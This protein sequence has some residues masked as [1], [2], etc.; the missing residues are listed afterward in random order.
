MHE[1]R[2]LPLTLIMDKS[3]L[4]KLISI[5]III[6]TASLYSCSSGLEKEILGAWRSNRSLTIKTFEKS[7]TLSEK[8][9]KMLSDPNFFGHLIHIYYETQAITIY[10]GRCSK[11]AYIIIKVGDNYVDIELYDTFLKEKVTTRIF[12]ENDQMWVKLKEPIR[13]Y[14]TRV[15]IDKL[16]K[17]HEC[18]DP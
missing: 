5:L 14:F 16:I 12:I 18:L 10:E 15:D 7:A 13:E 1:A 9:K 17:E 8:Q 2:S 3:H 4:C 11:S 6:T